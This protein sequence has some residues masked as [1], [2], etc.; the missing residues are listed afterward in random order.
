MASNEKFGRYLVAS[1]DIRAGEVILT[2]KPL[3]RGPSQI[4]CPVC[5]VCL[6]GLDDNDISN[7]NQ[8]CERCGWPLC[9]QCKQQS[10]SKPLTHSECDLT[11]GRGQ[12][13]SLQ[14]YFNPH[15]TYQ[16][17]TVL[18]CLLLKQRAPELYERLMRLESHCD[19]RR[20]S[21]QWQND[22]EGTAKFIGRFFKCPTRWSEEEILKVAGIVQ[23]NGHEVPLTEPA[24]VAIYDMASFLEHSCAPN[25]AKSFTSN[26]SLMLWAP[27]AIKKGEHLS[28]CYSDALWGT[29]N[30]Q[31]HLQQTKMFQCDCIRCNDITEF[32]TYFSAI[33]CNDNDCSGLL[34]PAAPHQWRASWKC[35]LCD[36]SVEPAYVHSILERADRDRDAMEKS[37]ANQCIKWVETNTNYSFVVD[38]IVH[39]AHADID[40][41]YF[42][43][44]FRW[45]RCIGLLNITHSGY[46]QTITFYAMPS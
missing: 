42:S 20:G 40:L 9:K 3:I 37:D 1:R 19:M 43:R 35:N 28:I 31:N 21:L 14:N 32:G 25:L 16:C 34:L 12:K 22:R 38:L 6:H 27:N 24:H 15:P 17:I 29:A 39:L 8:Q 4:T 44:N 2:E 33:K 11:V 18:R 7:T 30:R 5:I 41:L 23:V 26:T 36:K 13:V 10:N 46:R 45:H